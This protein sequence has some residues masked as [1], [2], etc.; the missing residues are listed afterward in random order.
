M[1]LTRLVATL[2]YETGLPEDVVQ[3]VWYF[4]G[5]LGA[6]GQLG[7]AGPRIANFYQSLEGYLS[8]YIDGGECTIT[9]YDMTLPSPRPPAG[10]LP[11]TITPVGGTSLPLEVA[12][13]MSYK[14]AHTP[15]V[16]L[17]RERGRLYIGPF[18]VGALE[19][20]TESSRPAAPLIGTL[21]NAGGA[22][23]DANT[24][25]STWVVYSPTQGGGLQIVSGWVD[26]A[27]DTQRRRGSAPTTR[28]VFAP[29]P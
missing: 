27:W 12:L 6:V 18:G 11:F 29:I 4:D 10:V 16:A 17:A 24:A 28:D 9:A 23:L 19:T 20:G 14:A 21:V 26:N 2:P 13:C 1:S 8:G 3:N 25:D 15:G 5:A 22:M 7:E